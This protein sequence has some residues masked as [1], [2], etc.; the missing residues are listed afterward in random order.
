MKITIVM[1]KEVKNC[2]LNR[3]GLVY[4]TDW[5]SPYT[6]F[7]ANE[8]SNPHRADGEEERDDEVNRSFRS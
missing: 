7:I 4:G 3:K 6:Y 8:L 5:L 2:C 1:K